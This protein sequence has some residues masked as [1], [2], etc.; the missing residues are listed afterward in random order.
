MIKLLLTLLILLLITLTI[1]SNSIN[2]I[3]NNKVFINNKDNKNNINIKHN[4]INDKDKD[5]DNNDDKIYSFDSNLD[6]YNR[7]KKLIE[8]LN[9]N[10]NIKKTL[11]SLEERIAILIKEDIFLMLQSF[12]SIW[13]MSNVIIENLLTDNYKQSIRIQSLIVIIICK[14]ID[15]M[16]RMKTIQVWEEETDDK[17][18]IKKGYNNEK[19]NNSTIMIDIANNDLNKIVSSKES[20]QIAYAIIMLIC[21]SPKG[22]FYPLILAEIPNIIRYI[23][24]I[25][26][27]I[28]PTEMKSIMSNQLLFHNNNNNNNNNSNSSIS[29]LDTSCESLAFIFEFGL[30]FSTLLKSQMSWSRIL[31]ILMIIQYSIARVSLFSSSGNININEILTKG[32][33]INLKGK[34]LKKKG[35]KG[36]KNN[37]T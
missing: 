17:I 34:E 28:A 6:K 8:S 29:I 24:I 31:Q 33:N 36:K 18:K 16:I 21:F 4:D 20:Q 14:I 7:Y 1:T 2:N 3:N 9:N 35:K 10:S 15:I 27:V 5:D 30:L 19:S 13:T 25:T 11:V 26:F 23:V 12:L 22:S 32:I 37:R